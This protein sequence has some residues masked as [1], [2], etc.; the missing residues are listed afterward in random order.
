MFFPDVLSTM[1]FI[2]PILKEIIVYVYVLH[3][4]V[5]LL[6][7]NNKIFFQNLEAAENVKINLLKKEASQIRDL[8]LLYK[9]EEKIREEEEKKV[10][11]VL[12]SLTIFEEYKKLINIFY[13]IHKNSHIIAHHN[14]VFDLL[15]F[16]LLDKI[17]DILMDVFVINP[18]TAFKENKKVVPPGVYSIFDSIKTNAKKLSE[19]PELVDN[20]NIEIIFSELAISSKD[21]T[22]IIRQTLQEYF[23]VCNKESESGR[24][25]NFENSL[26]SMKKPLIELI[27][28][29]LRVEHFLLRNRIISSYFLNCLFPFIIDF[30]K[31]LESLNLTDKVKNLEMSDFIR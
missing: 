21:N 25:S 6:K 4:N 19:N 26:L 3:K 23:N 16:Y 20:E 1:Y 30:Y 17:V 7:L 10:E 12:K 22:E 13:T 5:D 24:Y 15:E 29:L 8:E 11:K 2:A 31:K 9:I 27:N 18:L 14:L 28:N